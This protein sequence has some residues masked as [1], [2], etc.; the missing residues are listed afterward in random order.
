MAQSETVDRILDA[1]EELFAERGFSETSLRMITSKAKVNLAAVNYHFG[2][3][4]AL[5]H[6]VFARF[7]TPFCEALEQAFDQLEARSKPPH[8]LESL[9]QALT[10]TAIRSHRGRHKQGLAIFMRLLGLAYTQSQGHLRK[11]LEAEYSQTFGRFMQLLKEATPELTAVE[12]YWRIQFMMGATIF[13]MSSSEALGEILENKLGISTPI[14]EIVSRM[15]PFLAAGMQ[16]RYV[17]PD[18]APN[19]GRLTKP[20]LQVPDR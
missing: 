3:K 16:A 4:N 6:A 2:S 17:Q 13:T 15:V 14:E 11:F 8:C 20:A 18:P 12:R 19:P 1:A 10:E 7:L 5:I 9:L